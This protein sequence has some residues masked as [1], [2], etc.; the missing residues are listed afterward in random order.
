MATPFQT[1]FQRFLNKITDSDLASLPQINLES[2]MT[3]YLKSSIVRFRKCK[4]DLKNFDLVAQQFNIDLSMEEIEI[5]SLWMKLEWLDQQIYK[6][7]LV[8][9]R[10]APKD[11]AMTSQANHLNSLTSLRDITVTDVN[12]LMKY[13]SY[14]NND[15]TGLVGNGD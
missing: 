3:E 11:F 10:L 9:Q 8:K 2:I 12:N 15:L 13:Y 1:I 5:L 7:E 6:L 14:D 4:Q